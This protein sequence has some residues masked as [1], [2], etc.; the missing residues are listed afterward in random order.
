MSDSTFKGVVSKLYEKDWTDRD[1]GDEIVLHSFQIESS[2]R[3]FRTGTRKPTFNEGESISFVADDKSGNVDLKSVK[4]IEAE[5]V[6]AP[7][8]QAVSGGS[9]ATAGGATSRDAYWANKEKYDLE[10]RAPTIAYSAAQKNATAIVAAAL[11]A[12]A[13]SFGSTAKGKR[14][15]M[16]VDF[17]ELVTLRLAAL[18]TQAPALL[19]A[20]EP[21]VGASKDVEDE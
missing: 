16:L 4:Q 13:L 15:D 20:Y 7:K 3:Y 9:S 5:T 14:L 18:Q 21:M 2:R 19:D 1:S 12:D 11:G 17:I 10:V 8:P 6:Q